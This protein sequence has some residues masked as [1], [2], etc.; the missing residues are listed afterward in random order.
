METTKR[1]KWEEVAKQVAAIK[2]VT[3]FEMGVLAGLSSKYDFRD[4][5]DSQKAVPQQ[6]LA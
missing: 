4:R 1:E 2:D 6:D 5:N 3:P